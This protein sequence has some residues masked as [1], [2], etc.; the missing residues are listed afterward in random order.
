MTNDESIPVGERLGSQRLYGLGDEE[1]SDGRFL[2]ELLTDAP[3]APPDNVVSVPEPERRDV[4]RP[5]R[6][7]E[8]RPKHQDPR[9]P[10]KQPHQPRQKR[11]LRSELVAVNWREIASNL[12]EIGGITAITAGSWLIRAWLG[13]IV[14]G[15][16]LIIWGVAMGVG[17]TPIRPKSGGN[18]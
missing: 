10:P 16:L 7:D 9:K 15:T 12:A 2:M 14:M 6:R 13:L 5:E 18:T 8:P 3:I 4:P 17:P 1:G 11:R